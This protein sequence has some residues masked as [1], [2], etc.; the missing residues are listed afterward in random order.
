MSTVWGLTYLMPANILNTNLILTFTQL[1]FCCLTDLVA[2]LGHNVN[3]WW[4]LR[5]MR[6]TGVVPANHFLSSVPFLLFPRAVGKFLLV[7]S[8]TLFTLSFWSNCFSNTRQA[9]LSWQ[10]ILPGAQLSWQTVLPEAKPLDFQTAIPRF[11]S[12]KPSALDSVWRFTWE[13]YS[14]HSCGAPRLSPHL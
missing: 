9:G 14:V 6:N 4:Y 13:L 10:T 2:V 1:N 8:S 3:F 11:W 12:G 7:L 5:T